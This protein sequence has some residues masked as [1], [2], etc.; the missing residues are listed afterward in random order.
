MR[1]NLQPPLDVVDHKFS[2]WAEKF[3]PEH[4]KSSVEHREPLL[5]FTMLVYCTETVCSF[6]I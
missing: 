1:K 6:M 5:R 3:H 2:I 4:V